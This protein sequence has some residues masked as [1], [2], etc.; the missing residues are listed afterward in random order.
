M[1]RTEKD[2]LIGGLAVVVIVLMALNLPLILGGIF[3]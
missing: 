2:T 1:T 3:S